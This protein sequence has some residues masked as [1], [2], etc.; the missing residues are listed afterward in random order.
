MT[1]RQEPEKGLGLGF[2]YP[3][4]MA[5]LLLVLAVVSLFM[6]IVSAPSPHEA[7]Y[8][9]ACVVFLTFATII[10]VL[11]DIRDAVTRPPEPP[12][13]DASSH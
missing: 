10:S 9:G 3:R 12:E 13:S 8:Y 4:L 1:R 5:R 6:G 7:R 2:S 11:A